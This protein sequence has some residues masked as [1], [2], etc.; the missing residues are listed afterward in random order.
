MSNS[1]EQSNKSRLSAGKLGAAC[2]VAALI[3]GLAMQPAMA[4]DHN[5]HGYDR[6]AGYGYGYGHGYYG[7]RDWRGGAYYTP[8]S[9]YAPPPVYYPPRPSPGVSLF[10]PLRIR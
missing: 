7:R 1:T 2:A 8:Y 10:F 3:G 9:V 6:R 5:H 4:Y